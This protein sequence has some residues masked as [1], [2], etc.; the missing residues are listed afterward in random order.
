MGK[1]ASGIKPGIE[2]ERET[3]LS[4]NHRSYYP[5]GHPPERSDGT[6]KLDSDFRRP[7]ETTVSL[8]AVALG[9]SSAGLAFEAGLAGVGVGVGGVLV[10]VVLGSVYGVAAHHLGTMA[11]LDAPTAVSLLA[12]ETAA[13]FLFLAAASRGD[14]LLTWSLVVPTTTVFAVGTILL[15]G[16]ESLAVVAGTLV[17][18]TGGLVYCTH[19]YE[20]VR[21]G[22][23]ARRGIE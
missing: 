8:L 7:T 2:P 21:L 3:A 18:G 5:R 17:V 13:V 19:R 4:E 23:A 11:L 22:L 12:L 14:R 6:V 15:A 20:R 1:R 10:A 9:A 16:R